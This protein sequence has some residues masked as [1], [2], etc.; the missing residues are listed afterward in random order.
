MT[1]SGSWAIRQKP[2]HP[3]NQDL[4]TCEKLSGLRTSVHRL[5][6]RKIVQLRKP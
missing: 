1:L 3:E 2:A 6:L 5:C 4:R